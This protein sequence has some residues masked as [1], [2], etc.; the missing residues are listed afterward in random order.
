MT[1]LTPLSRFDDL[2][3]ELR[4]LLPALA[5][6]FEVMGMDDIRLD[7]EEKE[8]SYAVCAELPGVEKEDLRINVDGNR[9][10]IH[11]EVWHGLQ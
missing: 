3:F 8:K 4:C 6:G 2:L 7:I 1:A 11:A 10:A 9:V 5:Q